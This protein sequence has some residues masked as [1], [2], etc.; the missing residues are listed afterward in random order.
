MEVALSF[1]VPVIDRSGAS[2]ARRKA[3]SVAA[4]LGF[5]KAEIAT[6]A[7]IVTEAAK[8]LAKYATG[9]EMIVQRLASGSR[10]GMEIIA[11]DR[12]PGMRNPG[13]CLKD[14]VSTGGSPGTGLGAISRLST[15]FDIFSLPGQG[16]AVLSRFWSKTSPMAPQIHRW[17][18]GAL[19]VPKP[20]ETVS[21]DGYG[22]K[23]VADAL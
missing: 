14:G 20:G 5:S 9:G 8:N 23:E 12:G 2:E 18:I 11:L 15:V 7:I 4:R 10:F 19:C 1:K 6:I 3:E 21:G 13:A 16:T 22:C 17:E